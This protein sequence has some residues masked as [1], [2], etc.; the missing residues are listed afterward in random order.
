VDS[1][2]GSHLALKSWG[3]FLATAFRAESGLRI[4]YAHTKQLV[5][6][7]LEPDSYVFSFVLHFNNF[8]LLVLPK[9]S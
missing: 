3:S 4:S 5:K 2:K 1:Y 7:S 9:K 6:A 8:Y